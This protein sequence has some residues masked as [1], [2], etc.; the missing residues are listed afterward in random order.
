MSAKNSDQVGGDFK[1]DEGGHEM[2]RG[3]AG[4]ILRGPGLTRNEEHT[5]L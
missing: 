2:R 5:R 4:N 3:F 1:D